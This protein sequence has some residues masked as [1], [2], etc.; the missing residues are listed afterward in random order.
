MK[1]FPCI[2][3]FAL[4]LDVGAPG[5][6]RPIPHDIRSLRGDVGT[7]S[8][9]VALPLT[10]S[11]RAS[12]EDWNRSMNGHLNPGDSV[13]TSPIVEF[14]L[15]TGATQSWDEQG[16]QRRINDGILWVQGPPALQERVDRLLGPL[17]ERR[18]R[19]LRATLRSLAEIDEAAI[20]GIVLERGDAQT[21]SGEAPITISVDL[22]TGRTTRL[23]AQR[24][25]AL[26]VDYDVEVAEK[27]AIA[28]PRVISFPEGIE[29][30]LTVRAAPDGKLFLEWTARASL[31]EGP[32]PSMQTPYGRLSLPRCQSLV[33][34]GSAL[35]VNGG[36][37]V[38][39][40]RTA[41][42][43]WL[44]T[45]E[46]PTIQD[47]GIECA[48]LVTPSRRLALPVEVGIVPSSGSH[49]VD[50]MDSD[51]E[52]LIEFD[53]L[54]ENLRGEDTDLVTWDG[55]VW[56]Q[57]DPERLASG[58]KFVASLVRRLARTVGVEVRWGLL[59]SAEATSADAA[60]L[61]EKLDHIGRI[62]GRL[63]DDLLLLAGKEQNYVKDYDVEIASDAQIG[64]VVVATLFQGLGLKLRAAAAGNDRVL[65]TGDL[66][67]QLVEETDREFPSE[68]PKM[69]SVQTPRTR[70]VTGNPRAS[71]TLGAWHVLHV[72]SLGPGAP[73]FVVVVRAGL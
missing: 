58:R 1:L 54:T 8:V 44:L 14:M 21:L 43:P 6:T 66:S 73:S 31:A 22:R 33:T 25:R 28:D 59:S 3:L 29:M 30:D 18:R 45:V 23:A 42:G 67:F 38:M 32:P 53:D 56:I 62:S 36:G 63:G 37:V 26:V 20:P 24:S 35:I 61:A 2:L 15:D 65:L 34:A 51:C 50:D 7:S 49:E 4:I 47:T 72:G 16:H 69:G 39:G 68:Q 17:L 11:L 60:G 19:T 13:D 10:R 9:P 55:A 27:S 57:K 70:M 48:P 46:G 52:S 64:D 12:G 71:V 5:Q 40:S 41:G